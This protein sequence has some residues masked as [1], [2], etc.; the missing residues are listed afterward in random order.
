MTGPKQPTDPA[1]APALDREYR[2]QH[3]GGDRHDI[4]LEG[5]GRDLNSLDRAQDR[6]RRSDHRVTKKQRGAAKA[7]R[8]QYVAQ[9]SR[10]RQRERDQCHRATFALIVGA[11]RI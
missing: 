1:A 7:D 6:N 8:Q 11:H 9:P 5:R 4:G 2:N 3:P 10:C